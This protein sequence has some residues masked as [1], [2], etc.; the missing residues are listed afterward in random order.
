MRIEGI[1]NTFNNTLSTFDVEHFEDDLRHILVISEP[2]DNPGPSITN[3]AESACPQIA[4][5]LGLT[6]KPVVFIECYTHNDWRVDTYDRIWL[7]P[8]TL[9][10]RHGIAHAHVD[11]TPLGLEF[12]LA[13]QAKMD[14]PW[15][16]VLGQRCRFETVDGNRF[17]AV[18]HY[19]DGRR[20]YDAE[21]AQICGFLTGRC[22]GNTPSL[23]AIFVVKILINQ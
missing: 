16:E 2:L 8:E 23:S 3:C 12:A 18:A 11:W 10:N 1:N 13:L 7:S 6:A 19:Y 17:V 15:S 22:Q 9:T 21:K 5:R 14:R 20:Y 4:K